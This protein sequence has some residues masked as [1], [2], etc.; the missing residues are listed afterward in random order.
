MEQSPL[1]TFDDN[2]IDEKTYVRDRIVILGRRS[3]G[4]TVFISSLYS[5]LWDS[6]GEVTFEEKKRTIVALDYPG[7][8]FTNAFVKEIQTEEV[9]TLLDHIDHAQALILLIDPDHVVN[10]DVTSKIDNNYGLLQAINRVQNWPDGKNIPIV[11]VLTKADIHGRLIKKEGGTQNFITKYF[12]QIIRDI[13]GIKG[14]KL[15]AIQAIKGREASNTNIE[16]PLLY[17]LKKIQLNENKIK[18]EKN[19][20]RYANVLHKIKKEEQKKADARNSNIYLI[21]FFLFVA[22]VFIAYWILPSTVWR[23]LWYNLFG[24]SSY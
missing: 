12:S 11:M 17:C 10:G 21:S 14:C 4:K 5:K 7:E 15:S 6:N 18:K 9:N 22:L 3:S 19:K 13:K 2:F 20:E 1:L 8:V 16:T 24:G 23:N